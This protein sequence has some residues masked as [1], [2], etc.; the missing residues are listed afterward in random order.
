MFDVIKTEGGPTKYKYVTFLFFFF[1]F[2]VTF[3]WGEGSVYH[4]L[5]W[6]YRT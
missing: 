4:Y 5:K 2:V 1:S 6:I 3:L